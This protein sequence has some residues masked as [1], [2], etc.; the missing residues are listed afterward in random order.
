MARL[1]NRLTVMTV[2]TLGPGYHADGHGLYLRVSGTGGRSWAFRYR[3]H[4]RLREMGL[5]G[6]PAVGLAEARQKAMEARQ[7]LLAGKDPIAE[8]RARL[9]AERG[10]ITFQEA[11]QRYIEAAKVGWKNPKHAQQWENTLRDY[12]YPVLGRL[13]VHEIDT[14]LVLKVLE[15]IWTAKPETAS[16]LRGRIEA[17]LAW[18]T[19]RGY[20]EGDN[21]ARWRNHLDKLLPQRGRVAKIKHFPA[22]PYRRMGAFMAELRAQSGMAARAL[23]FAILTAAR[24]GEV[25]GARWQEIDWEGRRWIVPAERMKA[26]REHHVPLSD[27]ALALLQALPRLAGCELIFPSP[28]GGMLS[29]MALTAVVRRMNAPEARW[30]DASGEPITVHGFRATF[31][32]WA[33]EQTGFARDVIEHALAHRIADKAE[34]AYQRGTLFDKRR[35]LMEAWS[36]YCLEIHGATGVVAIR[37]ATQEIL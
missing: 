5:G 37:G 4:G 17:V 13:P 35:R 33:G 26:G 3:R 16:R 15:P 1:G 8:R 32:D 2:K 14:G 25:R 28:K 20:R 7:Q 22:L 18:A 34:A 12:A 19:V 21:P 10:T 30:V 24:S 29:D 36:S 31:R 6:Y 11:A 23:E 27:A 9:A